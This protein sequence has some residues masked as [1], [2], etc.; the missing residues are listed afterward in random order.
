[1][2]W[3]HPAKSKIYEALGAVADGRVEVGDRG[4]AGKVYSSS[5]NKFYDISYDPDQGAIMSN[6]NV[7][8]WKGELGYPSIA[9]LMQCG[10][11]S[12]VQEMGEAMKGIPWKDINQKFKND[13]DA[14]LESVL[15]SKSE[16][17]RAKLA[18]FVE[19]VD[20]DIQKLDLSLLGQKT[21]PPAGY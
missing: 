19:Q 7:S 13:F 11:L 17:E 6:D 12:Y 2:K 16:S 8:Y 20:A 10:A 3:K 18:T 15:S 4:R 14:A 1:M 21:V 5:R 9:F